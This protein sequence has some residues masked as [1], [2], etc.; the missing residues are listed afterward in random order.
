MLYQIIKQLRFKG[1]PKAGWYCLHG[2]QSA[3]QTDICL[4]SFMQ[5]STEMEWPY[6]IALGELQLWS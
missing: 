2:W 1:D 4:S 3:I 6:T 5:C